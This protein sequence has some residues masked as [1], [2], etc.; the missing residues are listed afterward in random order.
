L[1]NLKEIPDL[2]RRLAD[3]LYGSTDVKL[4]LAWCNRSNVTRCGWVSRTRIAFADLSDFEGDEG[5]AE[6]WRIA[7]SLYVA[8]SIHADGK[9]FYPENLSDIQWGHVVQVLFRYLD[10]LPS[11]ALQRTLYED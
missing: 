5:V 11:L 3:A 9:P 6:L 10:T 7:S 4:L 2:R 1:L 8:C